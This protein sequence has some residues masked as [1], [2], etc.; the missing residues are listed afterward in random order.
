MNVPPT[1]PFFSKEDQDFI[2][3]KYKE[4]LGGKSFLSMYKYG[5]EFEQKFAKF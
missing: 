5:E 3:S 1:K 2:L 4:I